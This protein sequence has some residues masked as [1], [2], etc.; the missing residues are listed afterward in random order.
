MTVDHRDPEPM[1]LQLA[2]ILRQQIAN[3][4]IT[5]VLPSN[6]DLRQQ[7]DVSE[8]VVTHAIQTLADEGLIFTVPRRGA[9]VTQKR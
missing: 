7:H 6:R 4:E 3:G 1:Y 5:D 9:Y 8:Q 2:A